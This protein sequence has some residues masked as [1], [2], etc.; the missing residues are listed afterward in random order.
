MRVSIQRERDKPQQGVVANALWLHRDGAVGFID[1]LDRVVWKSR[2]DENVRQD[3][4]SADYSTNRE[5][6]HVSCA[7]V[8]IP[9]AT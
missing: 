2:L 1:W 9:F 5:R 3:S 7:S 6:L 8:P 4:Q